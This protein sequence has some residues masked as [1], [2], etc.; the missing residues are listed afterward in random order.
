MADAALLGRPHEIKDPAARHRS[1]GDRGRHR[2]DGDSVPLDATGRSEFA[3]HPERN[4][5]PARRHPELGRPLQCQG[6]G[7]RLVG[8]WTAFDGYGDPILEVVNGTVNPPPQGLY[9]CP[10]LFHWGQMNA[11]MDTA[12]GAGPHTLY[13]NN[14]CAS[15]VMIVVGET[16]TVVPPATYW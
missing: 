7:I 16:I 9:R 3:A 2:C 1:C 8:A 10:L 5:V 6:T 11:S 13:W 12:L 15:A 4:Q 14:I